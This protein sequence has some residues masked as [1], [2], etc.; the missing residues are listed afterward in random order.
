MRIF[1]WFAAL[2]LACSQITSATEEHIQQYIGSDISDVQ[3]PSLS[4]ERSR[5]I[6]FWASR[7]Y[8]WIGKA[9]RQW[10]YAACL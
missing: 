8:A 10:L 1:V 5:P 9:V 4:T 2:T 3:E 7:N 6:G